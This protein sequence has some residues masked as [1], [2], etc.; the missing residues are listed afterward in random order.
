MENEELTIPKEQIELMLLQANIE[1][2][3]KVAKLIE[4]LEKK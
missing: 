3:Q 4:I 2:I 1:L